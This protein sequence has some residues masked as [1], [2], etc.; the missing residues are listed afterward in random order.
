MG[1]AMVVTPMLSGRIGPGG[2]P[3]S[4]DPFQAEIRNRC[5]EGHEGIQIID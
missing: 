3:F 1:M 2:D 4:D 5:R